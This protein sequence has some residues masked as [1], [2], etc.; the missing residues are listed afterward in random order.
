M[1][2]AQLWLSLVVL[3]ALICATWPAWYP[4]TGYWRSLTVSVLI[5]S[6]SIATGVATRNLRV[7][8]WTA[9]VLVCFAALI[10][11]MFDPANAF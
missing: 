9:L 8:L 6:V 4:S 3:T 10:C 2:R 7:A 5:L 11:I 1:T